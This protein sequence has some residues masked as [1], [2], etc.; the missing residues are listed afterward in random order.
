M[1]D[2]R[3]ISSVEKVDR[4]EEVVSEVTRMF[5]E[6]GDYHESIFK[7]KLVIVGVLSEQDSF[8]SVG[9]QYHTYEP[10]HKTGKLVETEHF[11]FCCRTDDFQFGWEVYKKL[12]K[13]YGVSNQ[14]DSAID[15]MLTT[16]KTTINIETA[17]KLV[18]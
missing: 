15:K 17:I 1:Q 2:E 9:I 7:V 16:N 13:D 3:N 10:H 5:N 4:V 12:A 8:S 18:A 6:L 11:M 14:V